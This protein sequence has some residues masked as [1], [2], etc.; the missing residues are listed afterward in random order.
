MANAVASAPVVF[1]A[2]LRLFINT[3]CLEEKD[4]GDCTVVLGREF[5][6]GL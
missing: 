3:G 2:I 6:A 4:S 5:A 1:P